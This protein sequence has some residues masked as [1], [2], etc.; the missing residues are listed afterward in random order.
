MKAT[1]LFLKKMIMI[2]AAPPRAFATEKE[3]PRHEELHDVRRVPVKLANLFTLVEVSAFRTINFHCL[4]IE[5]EVKHMTETALEIE[6]ALIIGVN[7]NQDPHFEESIEELKNLAIACN[8]EPIGEIVQ[9]LKRFHPAHYMGTGKID[10]IRDFID[11]EEID[12]L[13]VEDELSPSQI[14]NLEKLLS[15]EVLDRTRLILDIF[16]SRAQTKEAK[17]Q[18]EIARLRYALPRLRSTNQNFGHQ[19]G[20]A[21]TTN[22]GAGETKQE[23]KRR[24]VEDKIVE[25]EQE[26]KSITLNR[27]IR[28]KKRA[29]SG[30]PIVALVGYTNAGKSTLMNTMVSK[31]TQSEDKLVFEKDMLFATLDTS[32]RNIK[33]DNGKSILLSDTV[34]FINKLPH[35][36]VKAFR[37]TLEEVLEADLL[38]HVIDSANPNHEKHIQ[39]TNETLAYIEA[40]HIPQIYI[41]NKIDRLNEP[42]VVNEELSVKMSAKKEIGFKDLIDLISKEL[43]SSYQACRLLIPFDQGHI[44]SYLKEKGLIK[45]LTYEETGTLVNVELSEA[46]YEKYQAYI[47]A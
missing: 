29:T 10:E 41:Y 33:F 45:E 46:D 36:L 25:L 42:P 2:V 15:I 31:F 22:R 40:D 39:V 43:F 11:R 34:G 18:V 21:G 12:V 5:Q 1:S 32:V 17:M 38:L 27:Q 24:K 16:A 44:I 9:N 20:G 14:R 28:R 35:H 8:I 7:L 23:L 6:R 37:S 30:V 3:L 19:R 47:K 26:L 13:I 4:T